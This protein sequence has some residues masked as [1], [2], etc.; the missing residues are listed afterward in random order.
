M[1]G[2][3]TGLD[4]SAGPGMVGGGGGG[5]GS[6][7]GGNPDDPINAWSWWGGVS[8][9]PAASGSGDESAANMATAT[10]SAIGSLPT[11]L[12]GALSGAFDASDPD[13]LAALRNGSSAGMPSLTGE[14]SQE[15]LMRMSAAANE[16]MAF[17]MISIGV[18]FQLLKG[19][20]VEWLLIIAFVVTLS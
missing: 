3:M 18:S 20:G 11:Q 15:E 10:L 9:N 2:D 8:P 12:H 19:F 6:S 4:G 5:L 1:P 16:W 14:V 7:S 13:A 17:M